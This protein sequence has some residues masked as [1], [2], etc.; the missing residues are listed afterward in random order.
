MTGE[1]LLLRY[2]EDTR[3]I[4]QVWKYS[5]Y[6]IAIIYNLKGDLIEL[7]IEDYEHI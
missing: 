3:M 6:F 1:K 7:I 4:V 2:V 5:P